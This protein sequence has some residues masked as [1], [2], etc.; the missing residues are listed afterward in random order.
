MKC[1]IVLQISH[2]S[3]YEIIH[4]R[5]GFHKI[6]TRWISKELTILHK[7]MRL[8]ICQQNLDHYDKEGDAILDRIITG[9][10]HGSTIMRQ[11]VNAR[12][13]NGNIHNCPSGKSSKA[14]HQ[15]KN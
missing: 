14:N 9:E 11:S 12:L 5:L 13:W 10:K 1:Q 7:Q 4:N 6:C 8:D 3:A 15:Q 2:G